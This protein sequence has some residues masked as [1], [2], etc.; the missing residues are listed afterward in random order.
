M[1]AD[2]QNSRVI[3]LSYSQIKSPRKQANKLRRVCSISIADWFSFR[4]AAPITA[5]ARTSKDASTAAS[6]IQAVIKFL[7]NAPS[8]LSPVSSDARYRNRVTTIY[9]D[10][11]R[12]GIFYTRN[13]QVNCFHTSCVVLFASGSVL[14]DENC[15]L[16]KTVVAGF[17]C[18]SA[19]R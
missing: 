2:R 5:H 15:N 16:C 4:L 1:E 17:L 6:C 13:N 18:C 14:F 10:T 7:A 12:I 9:R 19:I 3:C 11:N 8:Q